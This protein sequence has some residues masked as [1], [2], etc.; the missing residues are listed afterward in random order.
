VIN[1]SLYG[2]PSEAIDAAIYQTYLAGLTLV[3]A[4]GNSNDDACFYTPARAKGVLTVAATTRT[5][6]RA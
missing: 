4:A 2:T 3:T 5:D 6:S 1:L